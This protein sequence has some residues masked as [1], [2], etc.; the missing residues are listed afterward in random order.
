MKSTRD[1]DYLS[2]G[3]QYYLMGRSASLCILA[4]VAGNLF[5]HAFELLFK[6]KLISRYTPDDLQKKFG[7]D[8]PFIWES[9]KCLLKKDISKFDKL[10]D[11]LQ[12]WEEIRYPNYPRGKSLVM[13]IDIKRGFKSG[14]KGPQAQ[15]FNQYHLFLEDMDE[16][17]KFVILNSSINPEFIKTLMV[18]KKSMDIYAEQN[19][20]KL[21]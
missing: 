16:L 17:F 19:Y 6:F 21:W 20:H 11:G 10:I 3:I 1:T 5:H 9:F 8:L 13:V 18:R 15:K 12:K 4:P 2:I 7:H 14:I